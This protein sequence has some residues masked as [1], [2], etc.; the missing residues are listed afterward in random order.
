LNLELK[1]FWLLA[2]SFSV[3][4]I[5][6]LIPFAPASPQRLFLFVDG[7]QFGV[8]LEWYVYLAG[9]KISRMAIFYAFYLATGMEIVNRFFLIECMD[10]GD[11]MLIM[12]RPWTEILG[13]PIEFNNWKVCI[14]IYVF[15]TTWTT[16]RSFGF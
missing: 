15:V 14:L 8:T 3:G 10:L 9:E 12:N 6:D 11:Y 1:I 2:L 16:T 5:F 7:R 13:I 4:L